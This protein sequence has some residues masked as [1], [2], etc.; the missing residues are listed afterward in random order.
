M[1]RE[2]LVITKGASIGWAVVLVLFVAAAYEAARAR[3]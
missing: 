2:I 1:V 3:H